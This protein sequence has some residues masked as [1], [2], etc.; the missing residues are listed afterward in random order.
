MMDEHPRSIK[1][2]H[3]LIK[4]AKNLGGLLRCLPRLLESVL[5]EKKTS[6]QLL[7]LDNQLEFLIKKE[8]EN[9]DIAIKWLKNCL[10]K[11][12][13]SRF[14][15]HSVVA[16]FMNK[17]KRLLIDY[18][19]DPQQDD[20]V[21]D[22]LVP[23]LLGKYECGY[24]PLDRNWGFLDAALSAIQQAANAV[25]SFC[26]KELFVGWAK[27][28][29]K[30]ICI[31]DVFCNFTNSS[32][33]PS[34]L[35]VDKQYAIAEKIGHGIGN[36]VENVSEEQV[37][38]QHVYLCKGYIKELIY[39]DAMRDV[40]CFRGKE[41]KIKWLEL[42]DSDPVINYKLM[43][44]LAQFS[45]HKPATLPSEQKIESWE[46]IENFIKQ[47][48]A[49]YY[50]SRFRSENHLEHPFTLSEIKLVVER[51]L[52]FLLLNKI[53]INRR[54]PRHQKEIAREVV[55]LAIEKKWDAL[56]KEGLAIKKQDEFTPTI[57]EILKEKNAEFDLTSVLKNSLIKKEV[58]KFAKEKKFV[59]KRGPDKTKRVGGF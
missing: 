25:A 36:W 40:F 39:P 52:V 33:I 41:G 29:I 7:H 34:H 56:S 16:P 57:Q 23:K 38:L 53:E 37:N 46:D 50:F 47:A 3:D 5:N 8:K 42:C 43:R 49:G 14:A 28:E 55:K 24:N 31:E 17:A 59:A 54:G 18:K 21:I 15:S 22:E 9:R 48:N 19:Y 2:V 20:C 58:S 30:T 45:N 10:D 51:F 11:L 13:E 35:E 27:I 6:A 1:N 4:C 12:T 32:N 44:F 26:E